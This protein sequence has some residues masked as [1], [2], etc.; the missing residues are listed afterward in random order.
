MR[1][2]ASFIMRGPTQAIMV[3]AVAGM[4]SLLLP[5]L[6]YLGSAAV[7]LVTLRQGTLAGL[8]VIAGAGLAVAGLAMLALGQAAVASAFAALWLPVWLLA[9]VLRHTVSL[10]RALE[11]AVAL[12]L[13]LI[14]AMHGLME[15][16]AVFW[17]R[18]I[19]QV[20]LPAMGETSLTPEQQR[21]AARWLTGLL[22][23]ALMLGWIITLLLARWW[24]ALLWNPGG[25][26]AEF[27]G[28]RLH[29]GLA[30]LALV[31]FALQALG[32]GG[33]G[34]WVAEALMV[35]LLV[36]L[37]QGLAVMHA[38]ND[39]LGAK[40]G[41]LVVIYALLF[42]MPQQA[43]AVLGLLGYMDAWFDVRQRLPERPDA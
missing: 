18:M 3:I 19:E 9:T 29:R 30:L 15:D 35:M 36:Y 14:L 1:G 28:L 26:R 8:K 4:L 21:E 17:Q 12:A 42:L 20:L 13:L 6:G 24:Q 43:V 41:W 32:Q 27:H 16:P 23:V 34:T 40:T 5:P 2:L 10:A 39:R 7:A 25:F 33:A 22:A 11:W 37:F 38:V 31:L